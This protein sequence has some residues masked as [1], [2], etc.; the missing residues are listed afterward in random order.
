ML[1]VEGERASQQDAGDTGLG[2]ACLP[3][4]GG[5]R[6]SD[7]VGADATGG[8]RSG[9]ISGA[10]RGREEATLAGHAPAGASRAE[11]SSP[12]RSMPQAKTFA[13]MRTPARG[14]DR[15]VTRGAAPWR[16]RD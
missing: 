10:R 4:K 14:A 8:R 11:A 9:A 12:T 13:S 2:P 7:A 5:Q 15:G 16:R 3:A 1:P 6:G